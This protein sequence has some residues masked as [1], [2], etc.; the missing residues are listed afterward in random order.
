METT[1]LK[2]I[3][4][5]NTSVTAW[6]E[7]VIQFG[8]GVLLR[9]LV[10]YVIHCANKTAMF[11]GSVVQVKS[12]SNGSSDAF[13]EQD[14]LYTVALQGMHEGRAVQE[15]QLCS[16]INRTLNANSWWGEVLRLADNPE[17]RIIVSNTTEAGI[18]LQPDDNI[19]DAPPVSFPGKLLA[20]LHQRYTVMQGNDSM[21]YVIIPT[22]LISNNGDALKAIVLELARL[23]NCTPEFLRW[24]SEAN[25]FCNSLVDRIVTGKPSPDK[26]EAHWQKLG[27]KD[28][29]LIEC[30]PY[31]LWAIEGNEKVKMAL[32]FATQG[33]GVL[34][35]PSIEKY[36]ELKLRLLNGTH[37]FVCGLAWLKGFTTV[38]EA[39]QDEGMA[40][41]IADLMLKEIVPTLPYSTDETAAFALSVL[42]RFANPF[43]EHKWYSITLNYTQ[44][45][46]FRNVPNLLAYYKQFNAV[47]HHM[48]RGF[49]GYI[50]FMKVE[51]RTNR[52]DYYGLW[53]ESQYVVNDPE[54]AA[55]LI[56]HQ[57]YSEEDLIKAVLAKDDWWTI[58][59]NTLPGFTEAVWNY[60]Q[61]FE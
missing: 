21:G 35:T 45:M 40:S 12:T 52:G 34:V 36:K 9:G 3:N 10:D 24:I 41:L 11:G 60:Y 32:S 7:K 22:E 55:F 5:S 56:L 58:D 48:A 17:L 28:Q 8:T 2:R 27:Y 53:K 31:L 39:M 25:H 4:R 54:A 23:N 15:Y 13:D 49:A 14:Q 30:E 61:T 51:G 29:L 42:D 6:P 43:I 57:R 46:A 38:K 50:R 47:P 59:L 44:K 19:F 33:S 26:L 20:L 16:S 37:S 18:V 1:L